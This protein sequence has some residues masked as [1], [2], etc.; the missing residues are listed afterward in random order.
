MPYNIT[1]RRFG[2]KIPTPF[3][4]P[5][6]YVYLVRD[7]HMLDQK[8]PAKKGYSITVARVGSKCRSYNRNEFLDILELDD[9]GRLEAFYVDEEF[10][11]FIAQKRRVQLDDLKR[12]D[13]YDDL[14][15]YP[16]IDFVIEYP[17]HFPILELYQHPEER[18]PDFKKYLIPYPWYPNEPVSNSLEE[19]E[20]LLYL[21]WLGDGN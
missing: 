8:Y 12:G 15:S 20:P 21:I 1:I 16:N 6:E 5:C 13:W 2:I 10:E 9:Q 4:R 18:D 11:A 7:F 17:D 19:L 14:D 3:Y